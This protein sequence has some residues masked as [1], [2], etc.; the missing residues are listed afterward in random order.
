ME[1][2][3][4]SRAGSVVRSSLGIFKACERLRGAQQTWDGGSQQENQQESDDHE[5]D[6]HLDE[7]ENFFNVFTARDSESRTSTHDS[8]RDVQTRLSVRLLDLGRTKSMRAASSEAA[9]AIHDRIIT[10]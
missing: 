9:R 2:A 10:C 4:G 5:N 3:I 7:R 6:H 8:L 1:V